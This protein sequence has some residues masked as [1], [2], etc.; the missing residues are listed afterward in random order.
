MEGILGIHVDDGIGGGSSVSE[1]KVKLLEHKFPFGSHKVSAFTFTGIEVTQHSGHSISLNQSAYV[2]KINSIS[3][4]PNRKTQPEL[5][6]TEPERL[7]LRGVIGSLQHAATNTRSEERAKS[8]DRHRWLK[9]QQGNSGSEDSPAKSHGC[10]L[11]LK[12]KVLTSV[13]TQS[14]DP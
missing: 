4:E 3:I 14:C 7:A 8:K 11:N 10:I 1:E 2:R 9:K 12:N 6:V 13:N 5:Q